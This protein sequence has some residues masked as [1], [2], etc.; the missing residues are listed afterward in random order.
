MI[1]LQK[2]SRRPKKAARTN[3]IGS[4]Q[5]LVEWNSLDNEVPLSVFFRDGGQGVIHGLYF[6]YAG[7]A[8]WDEACFRMII[9]PDGKVHHFLECD[10]PTDG[11]FLRDRMVDD[12]TLN[13]TLP[14]DDEDA[15]ILAMLQTY[16]ASWWRFTED[17]DIRIKPSR[18][19]QLLADGEP[20]LHSAVSA[21]LDL[22]IV[23]RISECWSLSATIVF[24]P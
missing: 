11:V 7:S 12:G 23:V 10:A 4:V 24:R 3:S 19:K 16:R 17:D 15:R 13:Q 5:Y 21:S 14:L 8:C 9:G 22:T 2:N 18:L 20:H 6:G 1:D